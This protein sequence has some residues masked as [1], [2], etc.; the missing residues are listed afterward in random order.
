[1]SDPLKHLFTQMDAGDENTA[2]A[3]MHD[4][5]ALLRGKGLG[6]GRVVERLEH[7]LLPDLEILKH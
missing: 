7:S 3:A 6:F 4:A 1:M 5:R 2:L